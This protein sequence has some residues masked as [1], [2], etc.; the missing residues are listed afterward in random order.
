MLLKLAR[1]V[2]MVALALALAACE[3]AA[4]VATPAP[5]MLAAEPAGNG[6]CGVRVNISEPRRDMQLALAAQAEAGI[7]FDSQSVKSIA[8]LTADVDSFVLSC[9][10][11]PYDDMLPGE[12]V[13]LVQA[14]EVNGNILS[15]AKTTLSVKLDTDNTPMI[16]TESVNGLVADDNRLGF[17]IVLAQE[18]APQRG[19]IVVAVRSPHIDYQPRLTLHIGGPLAFDTLV[20]SG[21]ELLSEQ[22]VAM[23][24]PRIAEGG[25]RYVTLPFRLRDL[26]RS[27]RY[28]I[29]A[30]LEAPGETIDE[31]LPESIVVSQNE[32]G[33]YQLAVVPREAGDETSRAVDATPTPAGAGATGG[34][35]LSPQAQSAPQP[36]GTA[37]PT[38]APVAKQPVSAD[39]QRQIVWVAQ[40]AAGGGTL[41]EYYGAHVAPQMGELSERAFRLNFVRCNPTLSADAVLQTGTVYVLP[42]LTMAP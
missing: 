10:L 4:G 20:H 11:A 25:L 36:A 24:F 8:L 38:S 17:R 15:S 26:D 37:T 39:G 40:P 16:H 34:Q 9:Q 19:H 31:F 7:H 14:R 33:Y 22:Q 6:T 3:G 30:R 27:G 23:R 35:Q 18:T 13:V 42:Q 21:F 5:L 29:K 1:G 2:C 28:S 32:L 12:Y 41:A